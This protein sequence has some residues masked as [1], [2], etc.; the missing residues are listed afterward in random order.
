MAV[1]QPWKPIIPD[2]LNLK[3]K[4]FYLQVY[5]NK[6]FQIILSLII[7]YSSTEERK[8]KKEIIDRMPVKAIDSG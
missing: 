8:K 2:N 5:S 4:I 3:N 6:N 1:R 7:Q